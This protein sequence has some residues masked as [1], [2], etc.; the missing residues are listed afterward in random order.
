MSENVQAYKRNLALGYGKSN[1]YDLEHPDYNSEEEY[2]EIMIAWEQ[3]RSAWNRGPGG[4]PCPRPVRRP[5]RPKM[6]KPPKPKK[7]EVH[8]VHLRLPLPF[9]SALVAI[10]GEQ[11]LEEAVFEILK[12]QLGP[13][14][15]QY[16][17]PT[18]P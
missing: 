7:E 3:G 14:L 16:S 13:L 17:K 5:G 2:R 9:V 12:A 8:L 15:P 1:V 4:I 10:K 11:T 6:N 18:A